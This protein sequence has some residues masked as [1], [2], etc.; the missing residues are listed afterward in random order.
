MSILGKFADLFRRPQ[1]PVLSP[2]NPVTVLKHPRLV[3]KFWYL[4]AVEDKRVGAEGEIFEFGY[5]GKKPIKGRYFDYCNLMAQESDLHPISRYAPFL[6]QTDTAETYDEQVVD[7]KGKGWQL[8][9]EDQVEKAK[10]AGAE[11]V[12]LDNPDAYDRDTVL[13]A[14]NFF[15]KHDL[16]VL[17]KNPLACPWDAT[18]YLAHE[19]VV[20]VIVENGAGNPH[21]MDDLRVKV[22]KPELLVVFVAFKDK[23]SDGYSWIKQVAKQARNYKN[24]FCTYSPDGEYTSAVEMTG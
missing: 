9:L 2:A 24:M 16:T 8:L 12:E 14:V 4:I 15:W 11:G 13:E 1:P 6:K 18:D 5:M 3:G 23:D 22:G 20:G 21:E 19:A 17:A 7:P 10:A